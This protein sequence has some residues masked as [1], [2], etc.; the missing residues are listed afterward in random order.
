MSKGG[1]SVDD[2]IGEF[3]RGTIRPLDDEPGQA[4]YAKLLFSRIGCFG[5]AVRL[6]GQDVPRGQ[7]NLLFG[8]PGVLK[9]P[10]CHA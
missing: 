7:V 1:R 6:P 4:F 2:P 9:E 5:D 10:H 8:V 3:L